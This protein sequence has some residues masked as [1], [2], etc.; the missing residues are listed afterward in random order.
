MR[1]KRWLTPPSSRPPERCLTRRAPPLTP[2]SSLP[3]PPSIVSARQFALRTSQKLAP[4]RQDPYQYLGQVLQRLPP[5]SQQP[6]TSI[7]SR[8]QLE[9]ELAIWRKACAVAH[10]ALFGPLRT[11]QSKFRN[12]VVR[13]VGH[14]MRLLLR[15]NHVTAAKELDRAF[16]TRKAVP[17]DRKYNLAGAR[18]V[19]R[20]RSGKGGEGDGK[21]TAQW[22]KLSGY[23]V[24]KGLG[25]E[26]GGLRIAWM[27]SLSVRLED[28]DFTPAEAR[29]FRELLEEMQ[30]VNRSQPLDPLL[31]AF[32]VRKLEAIR[33]RLQGGGRSKKRAGR[34]V[35]RILESI[36]EA[37]LDGQEKVSLALLD[38]A[39][40]KLEIQGT[41]DFDL[42][43]YRQVER[44]I[45]TLVGTLDGPLSEDLE[46]FNELQQRLPDS[47]SIDRHS[48]ILYLAIRFLLFRA[49]QTFTTSQ[50]S[51]QISLIHPDTLS[52][53]SQLYLLLLRLTS[54]VSSCPHELSRLRQRQSSA[55]YR[56][57]W[58]HLG[59]LDDDASS[60]SL[61]DTSATP[62][63]PSTPPS[64]DIS[65]VSAAY[66]LIDLTLQS[67]TSLAPPTRGS[68]LP[69]HLSHDP[70]TLGVSTK[71]HRKALYL[72]SL[73]SAP[74]RRDSET[75][76]P[77]WSTFQ[78][79]FNLI[80]Q[81]RFH[82][83]NCLQH[84][85]VQKSRDEWELDLVV[86]PA[87]AIHLLRATLLGSG[88]STSSISELSPVDG[89]GTPMTRLGEL[90]DMI[91]KLEK[92]GVEGGRKR[93]MERKAR[94]LFKK[95][96][97]VV[98]E[99]EWKGE[100]ARV[101]KDL[102]KSKI[103]RWADEKEATS[104]SD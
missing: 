55:L 103:E 16:F 33:I 80:N 86:Q 88:H 22:D 70:R 96:V 19:L 62:S 48:H 14:T 60:L 100:G 92:S 36:K 54:S 75:P 104:R 94:K 13:V 31:L 2:P 53:A 87:F 12:S 78:R 85:H 49:R 17:E 9:S 34:H 97:N 37:E 79:A 32:V 39:V 41:G 23:A 42:G 5:I 95:A 30:D 11:H 18:L 102:I 66:D 56:L 83:S 1:V 84:E 45:E 15:L 63:D 44:E 74:N 20:E 57:L 26:R 101:W 52:S 6:R 38:A 77:S 46:A 51:E 68:S 90:V 7:R 25:L 3:P 43:L 91:T 28:Q 82:D 89:E 98:V 47:E 61:F 21:V 4:A 64:H 99:N 35:Q 50:T 10:A 76:F 29:E 67:I 72:L 65:L 40:Q 73:P 24:G 27:Q 71:F 93:R 8:E 69:P 58:A 81:Q 59:V